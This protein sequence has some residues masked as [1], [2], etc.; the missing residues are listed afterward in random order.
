MSTIRIPRLHPSHP[1]SGTSHG[2]SSRRK[3]QCMPLNLLRHDLSAHEDTALDSR[4]YL[5]RVTGL[6]IASCI[7]GIFMA[8]PS[9]MD[10]V[11]GTAGHAPYF[12]QC[13]Q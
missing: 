4:H 12:S 9:M 13:S 2:P 3:N 10:G 1:R 7:P 6:T 11:S 8:E 5:P